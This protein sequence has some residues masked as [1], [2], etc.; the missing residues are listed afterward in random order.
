MVTNMNLLG[1]LLAMAPGV[2][3]HMIM[4][5]PVPYGSP[6]NSP[7]DRSG[8]DYPCKNVPYT[9]NTMNNWPVGSE[10]TIDFG[11]GTAVH[12]GGSGQVAVTLDKNPT[13]ASKFKVIHSIEGGWPLG[14]VKITL[15]KELPNGQYTALVSWFNRIGNREMYANCAPITV[16]GGSD[17]PSSLDSLPDL[18]LANVNV[19]AGATCGTKESSDYTFEN[20]GEYVTRQGPG[21]FIPLCG[22]APV[23]APGGNPGQ[24]QPSVQP[25]HNGQYT[26][27]ASQAPAPSV[28]QAPQAPTTQAPVSQPL[29]TSSVDNGVV[30]STFRTLVTVTATS[31]SPAGPTQ[32]PAAPTQPAMGGGGEDQGASKVPCSSDGQIICIGTSQFGIC[33]HGFAV[34]QPLAAGTTCTDGKIAKREFTHRNQRTAI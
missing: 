8:S 33:N 26:P 13:A 14:P 17:D 21:P 18:A 3:G 4:Q 16:T 31:G 22:G 24:P 12:G 29:V 25:P 9:I 19:G 6:N 11:G 23:D 20:P 34:P 15:P 27:P 28:T 30:T 32:P 5:Q 1:A 10:Q 7:L 2:F